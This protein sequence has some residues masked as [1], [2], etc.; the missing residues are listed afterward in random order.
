MR[1]VA[2]WSIPG[3]MNQAF[4]FALIAAN[5]KRS[6]RRQVDHRDQVQESSSVHSKDAA[7]HHSLFSRCIVLIFPSKVRHVY[8][9]LAPPMSWPYLIPSCNECSPR[10]KCICETLECTDGQ[11]QT[12]SIFIGSRAMLWRERGVVS[13]SIH[14]FTDPLACSHPIMPCPNQARSLPGVTLRAT[15]WQLCDVMVEIRDV[16]RRRRCKPPA[17]LPASAGGEHKESVF[18]LSTSL[19]VSPTSFL[20]QCH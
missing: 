19:S 9:R 14:T 13:R 20:R 18:D 8:W 12:I 1:M 15:A 3:H 4:G 5:E 17:N 6:S 7:V 2:L 16:V 11:G 10:N